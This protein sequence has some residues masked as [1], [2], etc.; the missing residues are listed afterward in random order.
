MKV[1]T[2]NCNMAFRN[3]AKHI[4][5]FKPDIVIVPE[6]EHPDKLKFKDCELP[7]DVLWYGQNV[8]KGLGIFS[9]SNL[10]FKLLNHNPDI[11]TILPI[12][13]TGGKFDFVL[14]AVWAY[15]NDDKHY[16]YIGQVWKAIQY[17]RELL[18]NYDVLLAGDF[19]S[20]MIWDKLNRKTNHTMVV[21]MLGELNIHSTYHQFANQIQGNEADPTFYLYRHE[22]K[23]Y[24]LDYC[25]ASERFLE[26]LGTVE[27]GKYEDWTK[28]S[29]HKPLIVNFEL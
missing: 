17:Y 16:N 8:H 10:K 23:P 7:N 29:D 19:N 22:N 1:I 13:V 15:N 3:K 2:W 4:L 28:L 6:C 24:H 18:Q 20:N 12:L 25:F 27:I 11:K 26:K 5:A 21:E 9:Y 14:F